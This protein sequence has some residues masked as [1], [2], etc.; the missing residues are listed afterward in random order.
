MGEI[1]DVDRSLQSTGFGKILVITI[2]QQQCLP[3]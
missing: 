3:S 1:A 2:D